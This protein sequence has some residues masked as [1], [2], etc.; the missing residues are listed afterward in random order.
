[1]K[2]IT[3]PPGQHLIRA[4][5][6]EPDPPRVPPAEWE[7]VLTVGGGRTRRWDWTQFCALPSEAISL[8]LHCV[9]GWSVLDT[10]WQAVSVHRLFCGIHTSLAH[11]VIGS[12]AGYRTNLPLEDLLE[13]PSWLA[14]SFGGQA[15]SAEHGG[16]ARLFVPHLYLWKS[17]KWVHT[18]TLVAH[19]EP[20]TYERAGLHNYGDP[21]RQQRRHGD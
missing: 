15:L 10:Q 9:E 16:P 19:D 3:L 17:V 12:Y 20:G 8:D 18:I 7:L 11:T 21:W 1:M 2:P 14:F 4:L 5:P 6:T 13:M